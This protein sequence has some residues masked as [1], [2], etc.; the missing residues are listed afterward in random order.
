VIVG[1]MACFGSIS[2][3][4]IAVM[5]MVAEMTGSISIVV[6]A[7]LAVSLAWM[8]VRRSDATIYESQLRDRSERTNALRDPEADAEESFGHLEAVLAT[9][10]AR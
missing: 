3:A 10:T 7:M 9:G 8:I 1:M 4:P 5:L 2:R 6:P